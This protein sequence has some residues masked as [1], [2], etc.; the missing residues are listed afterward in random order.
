[1]RQPKKNIFLKQIR[2]KKYLNQI[3]K[4]IYFSRILISL[5]GFDIM[6]YVIKESTHKDKKLMVR[7][8]DGKTI[9]FGARGYSD[10]TKHGDPKRKALYVLRHRR[11]E[12]WSDLNTAGFW[13]LNILWN[14]PDITA[15]ANDVAK[16]YGIKINLHI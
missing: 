2:K 4:K 15:S 8:P 1:M 5:P 14:K 13:A 6:A 12:D 10:Y 11:N 16:R 7:T 9:H 3:P